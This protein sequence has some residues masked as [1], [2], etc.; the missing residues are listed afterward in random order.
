MFLHTNFHRAKNQNRK[1]CGQPIR[2]IQD[3]A[4]R[5]FSQLTYGLFPVRVSIHC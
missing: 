2:L 1:A 5:E 3:S 4:E